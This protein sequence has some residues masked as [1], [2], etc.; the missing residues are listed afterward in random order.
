MDRRFLIPLF[1]CIFAGIVLVIAL[2]IS[3][4]LFPPIV[5]INGRKEATMP[6]PQLLGS[7]IVAIAA[8]VAFYVVLMMRYKRKSQQS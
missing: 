8:A 6:I 2:Y 5:I 4:T 3:M 1:S 7:V